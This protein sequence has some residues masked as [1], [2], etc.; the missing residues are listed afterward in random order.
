MAALSGGERCGAKPQQ[1]GNSVHFV[2]ANCAADHNRFSP[3]YAMCFGTTYHKC[4]TNVSRWVKKATP[5][6]KR[7]RL[8]Q[9]RRRLFCFSVI[10]F[11][12]GVVSP[13]L[14]SVSFSS[15]ALA[16]SHTKEILDCVVDLVNST[17]ALI[18]QRLFWVEDISKQEMEPRLS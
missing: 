8:F 15:D 5:F 16:T 10:S 11:A 12:V 4:I 14:W 17:S 9:K 3:P 1:D 18:T 6:R 13:C 7:R 2:V